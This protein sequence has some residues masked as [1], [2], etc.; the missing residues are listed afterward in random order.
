MGNHNARYH[1][2]RQGVAE[3]MDLLLEETDV[4]L[5]E[6]KM[7]CCRCPIQLGQSERLAAKITQSSKLMVPRQKNYTEAPE[8]VH[9]VH[10]MESFPHIL[11]VR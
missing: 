8:E 5:N 4:L 7:L 11:F 10:Q 3:R 9:L 6:T 2:K 1:F